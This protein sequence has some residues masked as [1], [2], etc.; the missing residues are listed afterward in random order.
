MSLLKGTNF[1]S[2]FAVR[3][4]QLGTKTITNNGQYNASDDN[5]NG[6]SQVMVD[7]ASSG[8]KNS[9]RVDTQGDMRAITDME[10][11]D[12]CLVIR[13]ELQN[14]KGTSTAKF[15]TFP[16]TVTLP[17]AVQEHHEATLTNTTTYD[18]IQ[19]TLFTDSMVFEAYDGYAGGNFK[20]EYNSSDG[21]NYTRVTAVTNPVDMKGEVRIDFGWVDEFGYFMLAEAPVFDGIFI[22]NGAEWWPQG[23]NLDIVE[24]NVEKGVRFYNDGFSEGTL[25]DV[26]YIDGVTGLNSFIDKYATNIIWPENMTEFFSG[27]K[28]KRIWVLEM[29]PNTANCTNMSYLFGFCSNLESVPV[30][31][32][33]NATNLNGLFYECSALKSI[34]NIN[35]SKA[36]DISYAFSGCSQITTIPNIDTSLVQN[37]SGLFSNCNKLISVPALDATHVT[38]ISD[39]FNNTFSVINIGGFINLGQS[40]E[41]DK[42][43]GW[44]DYTLTLAQTDSSETTHDS[45]MN[46]INNLYNI[47]SK[48]CKAQ[49]LIMSQTDYNKLTAEEIAIATNKGWTVTV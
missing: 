43:T 28:S 9:Y 8:S 12:M 10:E 14:M 19:L 18:S 25:G 42:E 44:P 40:Y 33:S 5:L 46:I 23:I 7:V 29:N 30:F 16:E 21:I 2:P 39:I 37:M 48:G 35:T 41:T 45:L 3:Y 13:K 4:P 34:P 15:L 47:K 11:N 6:Y 1:I 31:D 38:N 49:K 22:Y 32:T 36:T 17:S 20:I 24:K 27:D 26:S